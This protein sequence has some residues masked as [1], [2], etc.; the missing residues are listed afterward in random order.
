MPASRSSW[1]TAEE[2]AGP[3]CPR[4]CRR[5]D[6][7]LDDQGIAVQ[8]PDVSLLENFEQEPAAVASAFAALRATLRSAPP[9]HRLLLR[10]ATALHE[11][12]GQAAVRL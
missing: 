2:G 5:A 7:K 8:R 10:L 3:E 6:P 4:D 1:R 11:A 12:W 9:P